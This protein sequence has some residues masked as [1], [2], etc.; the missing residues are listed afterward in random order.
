MEIIIVD[1]N[2]TDNTQTLIEPYVQQDP[3]FFYIRHK[4]NKGNAAARNTAWRNSKGEYIAFM[5]D[6]DIWIDD[7]KLMKQYK[8]LEKYPSKKI[9]IVCSSVEIF[10]ENN[11]FKKIISKPEN[12]KDMLLKGNG[13]IFSPTVLTKNEVLEKT[14]GFD[15]NLYKGVDADFYRNA[16]CVY[17]YDVFFLPEVT[18]KI[19]RTKTSRLTNADNLKKLADS[20]QSFQHVYKKYQDLIEPNKDVNAYWL[21]LF[22]RHYH[23]MY[24]LT[25]DKKL[26]K[27]SSKYIVQS[28]LQKSKISSVK[29]LIKIIT[30]RTKW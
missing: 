30:N 9:G 23:K 5:D 28:L 19:D 18:T 16:V 13:L 15:E 21:E 22:S 24:L 7:D 3:R 12:F 26:R 25:K 6:D 29:Q 27:T 10:S 1:D 14:D 4:I 2:S 8:I 11:R 20:L 17:G